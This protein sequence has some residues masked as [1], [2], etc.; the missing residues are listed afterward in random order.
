[1]FA[2]FL[3]LVSGAVAGRI[4]KGAGNPGMWEGLQ[5]MPGDWQIRMKLKTK[6]RKRKKR[7]EKR[8]K[9]EEKNEEEEEKEEERNKH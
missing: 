9:K 2:V 5:A 3:K 1:M 8:K 4:R 7:K 6:Q